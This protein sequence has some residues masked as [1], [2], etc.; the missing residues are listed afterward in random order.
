MFC[1]RLGNKRVQRTRI[2]IGSNLVIP[3]KVLILEKPRAQRS[4]RRIVEMLNLVFDGFNVGHD[5][6]IVARRGRILTT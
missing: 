3:A 2:R 1:Q 6:E 5:D 4:K